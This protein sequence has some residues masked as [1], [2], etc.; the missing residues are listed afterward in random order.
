MA[1]NVKVV[2]NREGVRQLLRSEEMAAIC[3][4]LANKVSARAG[5]GFEVTTFT[6]KNRVNAS[7][8]AETGDAV[9]RCLD[10]NVLLKALR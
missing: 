1:K 2:L 4:E 9:Q 5:D 10:D 6:G 7:V 3:Q 8:R